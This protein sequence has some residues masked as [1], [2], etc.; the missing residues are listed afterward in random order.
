MIVLCSL[1]NRYSFFVC[2]PFVQ[3]LKFAVAHAADESAESRGAKM[4]GISPSIDPS[5]FYRMHSCISLPVLHLQSFFGVP[6]VLHDS[7][8]SP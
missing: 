6:F 5:L 1:Y 4:N 2:W 8:G 3:G 7:A